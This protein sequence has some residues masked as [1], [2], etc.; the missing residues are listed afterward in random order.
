[1]VLLRNVSHA[2]HIEGQDDLMAALVLHAET[3]L[4]LGASFSGS[5]SEALAGALDAALTNQ[6]DDL[7]PAP[8]DRVVS[9]AEVAPQVRKAM[10]AASL[11]ST[12]LI[13]AGSLGE[14]EDL[15]DSLVGH[16]AGRAQPTEPPSMEDWSLLFGQS[17][18]YL[19][20]EPWTRWSDEVPLGLE[21]TV[22]GAVTNYVAIVMGNAG[23]QRGLALYP[24]MALPAG[25]RSPGPELEP[26]PALEATPSGTLLLLLD[27]PGETQVEFADKAL[28]YGWPADAGYLPTFIG[29]G[30]D[31]PC[32]L[33]G[34]DA[35]LVQVALA[36][37]VALDSRGP[38]LVGAAQP[39][40]G[41]V[42]LAEGAQGD[43][44]VTQGPPA[45]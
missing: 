34:A 4:V 7:P 20:A 1:M 25:L 31:G 9:L 26:E 11:G 33:A 6:A 22:D 36:A 12:E 37:V 27:P 17:L 13:E 10:A 23:V 21:L 5:A 24:G 29:V 18:A 41:R 8:P 39:T 28:R 43:F 2:V 30:P 16:M 35:K 14:A 38:V 32:D 42:A 3:G 45:R 44:V 19:S 40:T 15:F